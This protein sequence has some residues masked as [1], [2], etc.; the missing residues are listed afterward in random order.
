MIIAINCKDFFCLAYA[1]TYLQLTV[2]LVVTD[3]AAVAVDWH[4]IVVVVVE[5]VH[6]AQS[7]AYLKRRDVFNKQPETA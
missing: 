6:H 3:M 5:I 1:C 4:D 7:H 2:H